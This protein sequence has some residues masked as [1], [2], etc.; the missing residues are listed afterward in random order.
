M[1]RLIPHPLL[2]AA[3]LLMWLLLNGFSPGHLLLGAAIALVAGWAMG[4]VEPV[5]LR[6]RRPDLVVLLFVTV[7]WD[8]LR[9]NWAVARLVVTRDR[10]GLRRSG[11]VRIRLSLDNPQALATLA[12]ILTATPG[13]AW[14]EYDP[15]TGILL[16]HVFDYLDADDWQALVG[17]RYERLLR[18]IFA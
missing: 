8:I 9:S 18:E 7:F 17:G 11:F 14:L 15:G 12:L 13:T 3:L 1:N 10:H 16:L 6:I 4:A 2:S 5:R